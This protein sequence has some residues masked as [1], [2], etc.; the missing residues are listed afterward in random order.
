MPGH[1]ALI[2][3]EGGE[4]AR[5]APGIEPSRLDTVMNSG[6]HK[7]RAS[8][9]EGVLFFAGMFWLLSGIPWLADTSGIS[10]GV[11]LFIA[12]GVYV[13][14]FSLISWSLTV[15][16]QH[17][18]AA[19]EGK[20]PCLHGVPGGETRDRCATCLKNREEESKRKEIERQQRQRVKRIKEAAD[21]LR[22]EEL[23]RLAGARVNRKDFLLSGT[24]REFEDGVAAMF[25]KLGYSVKQTPYSND[26]GKDAIAIK[27]GKKALIECKRYEKDLIGRPALQKFYAAIMEE[28]ADKGIFVTTSG[29]ARTALKY[30]YVESNLI[31][32]IEGKTLAHMMMRA[33]PESSDSEKYAVMCLQCGARVMFDLW[34]GE[35]R[36]MCPDNHPV[37]N[38]LQSGMLSLKLVSGKLYC[39]K[40][41]REMR[42][43][44]GRHGDFW[45]CAGYLECRLTRPIR[46]LSSHE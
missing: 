6:R 15:W 28:K 10:R 34:A 46:E 20:K 45:G 19:S 12:L 17:R 18:R 26:G 1:H 11:L 32:L 29:F 36:K 31:E 30:E 16:D 4:K 33:F 2:L 35:S 8:L 5:Q 22:H 13:S 42:R 41:G 27:D 9:L 7:E 24:P 37:N 21:S 23:K 14:L 38:D 39:D 43:V 40:C 25:E 3:P 44:H